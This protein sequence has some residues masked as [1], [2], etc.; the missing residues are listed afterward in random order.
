MSIVR[1]ITE[2]AEMQ[3]ELAKCDPADLAVLALRRGDE[4]WTF[5]CG[6]GDNN[7]SAIYAIGL[8]EHAK[9][10]ILQTTTPEYDDDDSPT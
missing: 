10:K 9:H 1:Y 8:L 4:L 7:E 6:E 2:K 3:R 5:I